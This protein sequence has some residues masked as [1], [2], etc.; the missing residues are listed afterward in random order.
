[1]CEHPHLVH[2]FLLSKTEFSFLILGFKYINAA[3]TNI[4]DYCSEVNNTVSCGLL[5]RDKGSEVRCRFD[6]C[7]ERHIYVCKE[8]LTIFKDD[9]VTSIPEGWKCLL[10]HGFVILE[11]KELLHAHL[12]F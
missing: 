9:P 6:S 4:S 3:N 11:N 2:V 1:M 10:K 8:I 5:V 12:N 7:D